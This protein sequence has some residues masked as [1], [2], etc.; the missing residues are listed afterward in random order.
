M[1]GYQ[2]NDGPVGCFIVFWLLSLIFALAFWGLVAYGI[3]EGIQWLQR[4]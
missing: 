1:P 3:W 2:R 4:N